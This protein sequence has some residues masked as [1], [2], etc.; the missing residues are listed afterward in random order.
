MVHRGE[1]H[2]FQHRA[3]VHG[4]V[5]QV[6]YHDTGLAVHLLVKG[7]TYADGAAAT[8]DGVI[9]INAEGRKEGVHTAAQTLV[10][11]R[12]AGENLGHGTVQQEAD[13]QF[14]GAALEALTGHGQRGAAPELLHHLLQLVFRQ[15]LDG[16][17]TL[18]QDFT[19]GTVAAEDEVVGGEVVGHTHG[20]SLLTGAQVGRTG[21]VVGYAIVA[22]GGFHQVEHGLKLPDYEH[23]P[24]NVLE[25]FL[26]EVSF[27]QFLL[28]GL[29]I[30][31]DGNLGELNLVL[32]RAEHLIGIDV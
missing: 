1:G 19:V 2:T 11:A 18:G 3:A 24:V 21:I 27:G 15:D 12:G 14:L 23:I 4:A 25:I 5:T 29:V 22:A 30:G 9:G 8:H 20:G 13:A 26:G 16:T 17:Q 6:G 32:L 7:R 28:H 10:E 31:H